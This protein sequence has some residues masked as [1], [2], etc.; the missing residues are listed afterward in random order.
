MSNGKP[1]PEIYQLAAQRLKLPANHC[2]ALED[3][4]NGV[5][6]ALNANMMTIQ[7]PDLVP[8]LA[9]FSHKGVIQMPTMHAA[10]SWLKQYLD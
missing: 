9:E 1:N 6:A 5:L 4:N 8:P 3:S 2:L 10:L 7:I